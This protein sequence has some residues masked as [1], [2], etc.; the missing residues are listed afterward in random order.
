[1]QTAIGQAQTLI[2]E[3]LSAVDVNVMQVDKDVLKVYWKVTE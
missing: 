1:V 3:K 2:I